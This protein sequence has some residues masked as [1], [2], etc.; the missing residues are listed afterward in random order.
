MNK[1]K[2]K[3]ILSLLFLTALRKMLGGSRGLSALYNIL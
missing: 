2:T 1:K 3:S